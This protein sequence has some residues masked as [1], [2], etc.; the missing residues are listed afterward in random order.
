MK[1]HC[2]EGKIKTVI[3]LLKKKMNT[4]LPIPLPGSTFG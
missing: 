2:I 4:R 1:F 3:V